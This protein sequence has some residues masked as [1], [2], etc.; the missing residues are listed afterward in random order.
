MYNP[1]NMDELA[2]MGKEAAKLQV[3]PEHFSPTFDVK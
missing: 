3:K 2:D 1:A